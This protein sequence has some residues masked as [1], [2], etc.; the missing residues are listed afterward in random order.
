MP[1]NEPPI[2]TGDALKDYREWLGADSYE[3]TGAIGGNGLGIQPDS[4]VFE[5]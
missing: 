1:T 5:G 2:Y 4:S 3:A